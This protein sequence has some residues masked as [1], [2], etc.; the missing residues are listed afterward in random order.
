MKRA[1]ILLVILFTTIYT[2]LNAVNTDSIK[3]LLPTLQGTRLISALNTLAWELKYS[4]ATDS[5][6]YAQTA[7]RLLAMHPDD[8]EWMLYYRNL[9]ALHT[10]KADFD[11][12]L[13][14]GEKGLKLAR[15]L[16]NN[17][18][19]GKLLNIL[20][21]GYREKALYRQ[22]VEAQKKAL[23]IFENLGDTAEILGNLNN[24]AMTYGRM[25]NDTAS[26][27]MH[28]KV[29]KLEEPRGNPAAIAR[30]ANNV[31]M[32]LLALDRIDEARFY[33]DK[34]LKLA[35]KADNKLFLASTC[36]GIATC[37]RKGNQLLDAAKWFNRAIEICEK[38][39]FNDFLASNLTTMGDL[40]LELNDQNQALSYYQYAFRIWRS[41]SGNLTNS[42]RAAYK[43]ARLLF[44]MG[45]KNEAATIVDEYLRLSETVD[46]REVYPEILHLAARIDYDDG[47]YKPAF[48]KLEKSV[49]IN[50]SLDNLNNLL[51]TA[52]IHTRYEISRMEESN[53][54]LEQNLQQ[55][56]T[57][58][59]IQRWVVALAIILILV[60]GTFLVI[61]RRNNQKL[62]T[63]NK[64]LQEQKQLI[65]QKT[66]ELDTLN[67]TKDKFFSIV[68]HDLKSPFTGIV[69]FSA[70]LSSDFDS[71]SD[72]EKKNMVQHIKESS[73]Q[74]SWL[75]D[76][77]LH[78]ARSQMNLTVVK[79]TRI[80]LKPF[81]EREITPLSHVASLKKI[82]LKTEI[83]DQVEVEADQEMLR[84]VVRNL[85]S[86]AL[87]FTHPNG[88][89]VV[90][91]KE[92]AG[93]VHLTVSDDGIGMSEEQ[94]EHLFKLKTGGTTPGT[95]NE[96]GTGLGLV[97]CK[98]FIVQNGGSI[99]V[100][101]D[102]GTGSTFIVTFPSHK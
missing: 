64:L 29:L 8:N 2:N 27:A 48:D 74:V 101:S 55:Q 81:I 57:I 62:K 6:T 58:N 91:A 50:D 5:W 44:E 17:Y 100:K 60:S 22:A 33:F 43:T 56:N 80:K 92:L 9:T 34:A 71:Y 19:Q 46:F 89:V 4:N 13:F 30:S 26:L 23:A 21:I 95:A 1:Y 14:Y 68:A 82:A 88:N 65:E 83:S 31:G 96:Q 36:F 38:N 97:L 98:D 11:S 39:Q 42:A 12:S 25:G 7:G 86:N 53:A 40:Y 93:K 69:G 45:R 37:H 84:F 63:A 67:K 52:N 28:L 51:E 3:A 15:D 47:K 73:E 75:L 24:L 99:A 66:I 85:V 87:K 16:N 70:L 35:E 41:R 61:L 10:L 72:E 76:N 49:I 78:W 20:S 59:T 77:L 90:E 18:Q 54:R 79:T 32:A 102:P 94:K